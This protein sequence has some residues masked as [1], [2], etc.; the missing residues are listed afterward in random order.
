MPPRLRVQRGEWHLR[1]GRLP[2]RHLPRR[3]HLPGWR[4]RGGVRGR[5]LPARPNLL[6]RQLHRSLRRGE[7]RCR[8]G[9][10][11]RHLPR[12]MQSVQRGGLHRRHGLRRVYGGLSRSLVP[13]GLRA[14]DVLPS[15]HLPRR[16]RRGGLPAGPGLRR[17][18]LRLPRGARSRRVGLPGFRRRHR[19]GAGPA[20]AHAY[21]LRVWGVGRA[22]LRRGR[23]LGRP[24]A[25]GA[26]TLPPP[27]ASNR[28]ALSPSTSLPHRGCGRDR[29]PGRWGPWVAVGSAGV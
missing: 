18:S 19:T 4:L 23:F 12:W 17:R 5:R 28:R 2:G 22:P 9:L 21:R 24:R 29:L 6:P 16:L 26:C 20:S 25:C 13:G 3:Q 14:R 8:S 11:G 27:P 1:G 15:R 7:L 10:P